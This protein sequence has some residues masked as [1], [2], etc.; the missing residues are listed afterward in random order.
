MLIREAIPNPYVALLY[1]LGRQRDLEQAVAAGDAASI[2]RSPGR[3][4]NYL[5][6]R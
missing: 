3:R 6:R 5:V 4:T 1:V 2:Q